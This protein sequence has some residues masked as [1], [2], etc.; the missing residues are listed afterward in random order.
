[1]A[2]GLVCVSVSG[3]DAGDIAAKVKPIRKIVDLIEVRLDTMLKPVVSECMELLDMDLLFTN[4]PLRE[5]G[6]FNGS[7]EERLAPLL[8]AVAGGAAFVDFELRSDRSLREKLLEA[9]ASSP[10][11]CIFS[12][13]DFD[14]TPD[15]DELEELLISIKA[16]GADIG[17]IVTTAHDELAVLRVL[18]LQKKATS[19]NLALSCFCMGE[20]G[21]ISRFAS[22]Y[23]GGMM[24]FVA[25]D[26]R[27]ATAPGQFSARQFHQLQSA[28]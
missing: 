22:L 25:V 8:E 21:R 7:E 15:E 1:M 3:I 23:L 6:Q 5:G 27:S 10:T 18:S 19:L 17:K 13:H 11:R 16:S 24:S 9:A 4:R 20:K 2:S 28:F 14:N 26:E 12:W